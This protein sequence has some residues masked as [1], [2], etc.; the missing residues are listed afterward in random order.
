MRSITLSASRMPRAGRGLGRAGRRPLPAVRFGRWSANAR[1]TTFETAQALELMVDHTSGAAQGGERSTV[2]LPNSESQ[3]RRLREAC[4]PYSTV[5]IQL[6]RDRR[7]VAQASRLFGSASRR[8][9]H[10]ARCIHRTVSSARPVD[11]RAGRPPEQARRLCYP[12]PPAAPTASLRF[13]VWHRAPAA[14]V[15]LRRHSVPYQS[16][17]RALSLLAKNVTF[18]PETRRSPGARGWHRAFNRSRELSPSTV[19]S[20]ENVTFRPETRCPRRPRAGTAPF[21]RSR[22]LSPSTVRSG[23][24]NVTFRP[25]TRRPLGAAAPGR[26]RFSAFSVAIERCPVWRENVTFRPEIRRTRRLVAASARTRRTAALPLLPRRRRRAALHKSSGSLTHLN[27]LQ[28]F[29]KVSRFA[30]SLPKNHAFAFH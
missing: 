28:T 15:S 4:N 3:G 29:P 14:S 26:A 2:P 1:R 7:W 21:D 18:R 20:R 27:F 6:A 23:A 19:R 5:S 30:H 22:E 10:W 25:E 11:R 13:K 17:P 9:A 8:V 16:S 12:S 24:K